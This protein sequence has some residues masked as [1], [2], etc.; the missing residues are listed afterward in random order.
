APIPGLR[1]EYFDG[2]LDLVLER[3]EP[4]LDHDWAD[5]SPG[6]KVGK[7]RFSV[8]WTGSLVPPNSGTYTLA[9]SSDDGVR[10]WL[11]GKLI[12]D[13]WNGHPVTR[14]TATVKLEA[15]VVVPIRVDY[16]ELDLGA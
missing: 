7:D 16:F 3:V 12:I 8:R 14:N 1:A 5:A 10:V 15:G 4:T 13:D 9:T 2:Y 6:P 11:S